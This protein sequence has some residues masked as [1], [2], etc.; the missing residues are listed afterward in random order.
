MDRIE[1]LHDA[2]LELVTDFD[3]GT[4]HAE[5]E[6]ETFKVGSQREGEIIDETDAE[7]SFQFGD[8]SVAFN[9]D[10]LVVRVMETG[11]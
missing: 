4:E 8:G 7:L 3:E 10:K 2:E 6:T 9:V 1:F 11:K 5:T